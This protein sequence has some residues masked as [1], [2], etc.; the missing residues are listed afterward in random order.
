MVALAIGA[1]TAVSAGTSML[2]ASQQADAAG[3]AADASRDA[4]FA[5]VAES[6]RQYDQTRS[7]FAPYREIGTSALYELGALYGIGRSPDQASTIASL[8]LSIEKNKAYMQGITNEDTLRTY[9][10]QIAEM[11]AEKARIMAEG[12]Y[13]LSEGQQQAARDRF[14]ETPGYQFAFDEGVRALDRSASA[15]GDLRGGGYG[16]ELTRYGQGI[17]NQEFNNY[18]NRLS[19]LA[20]VGQAAT[21]STAAAGAQSSGNISNALMAG[22]QA[23]GNALMAAGTARASGYA[24]V[25]NAI[26]SGV[27]NYM[28]MNYLKAA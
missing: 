26:N 18:A 9:R 22:G 16:R 12:G 4:T 27:Q 21:G 24:G 19:S 1:S 6:R 15:R 28:L 23:Q 2:A 10:T 17:A 13:R 25:G 7:D 5:S 20:G 3:D 11:E 8:D 14:Q